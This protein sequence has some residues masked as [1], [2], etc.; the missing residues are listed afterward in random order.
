VCDDYEIVLSSL[1][2]TD[3]PC[4]YNGGKNTVEPE[5]KCH[6]MSEIIKCG[7]IHTN[8]LFEIKKHYCDDAKDIFTWIRGTA[9]IWVIEDDNDSIG[10]CIQVESC[11]DLIRIKNGS[12]CSG[13]SSPKGNCF[14]NG[15]IQIDNTEV[16]CSDVVDVM[17]CGDILD[18]IVCA[19]AKKDTYPNLIIDSLSS[20]SA[21]YCM[22]EG[23][24]STC[25][26]K[27]S[28]KAGMQCV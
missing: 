14:F 11:S 3:E 12:Q 6:S 20:S 9:C 18:V 15:D 8:G 24:K 21:M 23:E 17:R 19:Y 13:Y 25:V 16:R 10:K 26:S 1:I 2:V 4:F 22:W 27:N 28:F 5:G 7:D